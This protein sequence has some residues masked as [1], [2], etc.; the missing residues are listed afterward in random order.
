MDAKKVYQTLDGVPSPVTL[1]GEGGGGR[2]GEG[3]RR[4]D[5][6][7][8][9]MSFT[10]F[11]CYKPR[12]QN[13][14]YRVY[15]DTYRDAIHICPDRSGVLCRLPAAES[16]YSSEGPK[17]RPEGSPKVNKKGIRGLGNFSSPWNGKFPHPP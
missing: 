13:L 5:G 1:R 3:R 2:G 10:F 7:L 15:M 4:P 6:N 8:I 14:I 17:E 9:H 16:G 11:Q 12:V